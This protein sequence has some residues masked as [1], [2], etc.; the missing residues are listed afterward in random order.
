MLGIGV[1]KSLNFKALHRWYAS[2]FYLEIKEDDKKQSFSSFIKHSHMK[3]R[4]HLNRK[5]ILIQINFIVFKPDL[6]LVHFSYPFTLKP[7]NAA[8]VHSNLE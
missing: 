7:V 6:V 4:L 3:S 2:F 8:F 5:N 1:I